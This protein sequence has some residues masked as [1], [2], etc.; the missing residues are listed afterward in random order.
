MKSKIICVLVMLLLSAFAVTAV[1]VST[2][3]EEYD[4]GE[5]VN[6]TVANCAGTSIVKFLDPSGTLVDIKSGEGN[7]SASYHTSSSSANGKYKVTSSCSNG[8]SEAN[9]CVDAPGCLEEEEEECISEWDCGE[10]SSCGVDKLE[11][12]TCVDLNDCEADRE[13]TKSCSCQESWTCLSWS[14][15]QNGIQTRTCYDQNTCGTTAS[16]PAVQQ[17]CV[18]VPLQTTTEE[19]TE[20]EGFFSQNKGLV[21]AVIIALILTAAAIVYFWKFKKQESS[22]AEARSW[23]R[24]EKEK[25]VSDEDIRIALKKQGWQEKD[26]KSVFKKLK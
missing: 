3:Q 18:D 25:G 9:F 6:A 5:I 20:E 4:D 13:E 21:I 22:F 7:W 16:K 1:D 19:T 10:W 17:S 23:V 14:T 11:R 12:R 8:M 24:E 2:D 15:C 26:I